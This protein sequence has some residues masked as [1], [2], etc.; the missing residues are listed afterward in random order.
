MNI[1]TEEIEHEL[2]KAMDTF[3]LTARMLIQKLIIET[4]QPEIERVKRG[5][6]HLIE[7]AEL[8]NGKDTLND[9]WDF[10]IHGEHCLFENRVTGQKIEVSLGDHEFI[11]NLDPY[12][13][14]DFLRTTESLHHLT[15]YFE[16][17]FSSVLDF[18]NSL[19]NKGCMVRIYKN[20]YRK[21]D[22]R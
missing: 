17:S 2:I 6:Y 14:Y 19:V 9:S 4:S 5:E 3:V 18:F 15:Q 8:L 16:D 21:N 12:F 7:D 13:F 22:K 10:F 11:E 1:I 20:E